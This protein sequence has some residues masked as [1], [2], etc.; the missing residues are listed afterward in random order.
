VWIETK[1][2][3]VNTGNVVR[4]Y[5][6]RSGVGGQEDSKPVIFFEC[7]GGDFYHTFD[8]KQERDADYEAL[9]TKLRCTL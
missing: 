5:K 2:G 4:F 1:A 8:T 6:G 3:V 9:K 7:I